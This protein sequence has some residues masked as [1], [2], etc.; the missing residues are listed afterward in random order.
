MVLKFYIP[1]V[2]I[3]HSKKTLKQKIISKNVAHSK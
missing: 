3:L 1:P 2:E